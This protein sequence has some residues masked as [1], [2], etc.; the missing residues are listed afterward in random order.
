M[1]MKVLHARKS[2]NDKDFWTQVGV[3]FPSRNGSG[4]TIKLNYLPVAGEDGAVTLIV[5][6][7]DGPRQSRD[8]PGYREQAPL[9]DE[10]GEIPW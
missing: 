3:A 5:R 8:A 2:G 10:T 9:D 1:T 7:D 4:F 6:E